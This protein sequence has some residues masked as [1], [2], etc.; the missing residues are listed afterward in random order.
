MQCR[1]HP[2]ISDAKRSR[3]RC[4][5]PGA[6]AFP[7]EPFELSSK[8][9]NACF[10]DWCVSRKCTI[11]GYFGLVFI[12]FCA[13]QN[14]WRSAAPRLDGKAHARPHLSVICIQRRARQ[15][16]R[17]ER[18]AAVHLLVPVLV[19]EE[20]I[21]ESISVERVPRPSSANSAIRAAPARPMP[22]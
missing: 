3:D 19:F 4:A 15:V 20:L 22:L 17:L 12:E 21:S 1:L 8:L 2:S 13:S 7:N 14:V 5:R 16:L 11:L 6:P 10:A 18:S 9:Q